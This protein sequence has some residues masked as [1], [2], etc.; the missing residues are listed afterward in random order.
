M[1]Q[2]SVVIPHEKKGEAQE[3]DSQLEQ[4]LY[5]VRRTIHPRAV[6]GWFAAWRWLLVWATQLVFYGAA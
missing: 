4:A 5:E 1:A 3:P 2:P 6:R